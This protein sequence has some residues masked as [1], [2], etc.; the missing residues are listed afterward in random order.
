M[1]S[2]NSERVDNIK[3]AGLIFFVKYSTVLFQHSI[4][5]YHLPSQKWAVKNAGSFYKNQHNQFYTFFLILLY[6]TRKYLSPAAITSA[7]ASEQNLLLNC[8]PFALL[9]RAKPTIVHLS[10]YNL[11]I[12]KVTK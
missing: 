8:N 9:P 2:E 4:L 10:A 12:T 5:R 7:L 1:Q 6:W 11:I 3:Q